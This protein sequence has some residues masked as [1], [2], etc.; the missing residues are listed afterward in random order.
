MAIK[1]EIFPP[2]VQEFA[3]EIHEHPELI[4]FLEEA[5]EEDRH[6]LGFI[7]ATTASYL[8]IPI[9]GWFSGQQTIDLMHDFNIRL[10]EKRKSIILPFNDFPTQIQ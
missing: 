6:D 8:E 4:K 7:L 10:K 5:E 3:R 1:L 2:E 9:D